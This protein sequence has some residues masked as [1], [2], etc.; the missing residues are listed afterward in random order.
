[1]SPLIFA[2]PGNEDLGHRLAALLGGRSGTLNTRQ[3]PDGETYVRFCDDPAGQDIVLVCTLD[4]PDSKILPLLFA[5][6]AAR[7]L[8]ACRVGLVAPYLG[9]LRQDMRFQPGEAVTSHSFAK[10]LS[11]DFDWLVTVEPHLHR[12]KALSDIYS[13]PA[14]ALHAA[15]LI[16][17]WVRNNI[18]KPH[19]IGPDIESRQ[20][21]EAVAAECGAT[22]TVAR[23]TRLGDRKVHEDP[24]AGA[25]PEGATPVL[26]DDIISSGATLLETLRLLRDFH[27]PTPIVIAIHAL[28]DADTKAQLA[29]T[30]VQLC[31]TNSVPNDAAQMD[32]TPLI[33][34][35][36]EHFLVPGMDEPG[37]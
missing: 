11:H 27:G 2:L 23:K 25:I 33:A 20:W 14:D 30:G 1:M 15:P 16:A 36:V 32:V 35:G 19:L 13:I 26:L 17:E 5:A 37:T 3:F 4:R 7:D 8:G 9:Y 18:A 21:V 29:K 6:E 12:Y 10:L 28:W 31:T 34:K 24:L 22:W